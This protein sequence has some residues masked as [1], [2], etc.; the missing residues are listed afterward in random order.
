[1]V[2]CK[3]TGVWY[4]PEVM[5]DVILDANKDVLARLKDR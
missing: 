3:I 5:L 4:D 1:M 2:Q